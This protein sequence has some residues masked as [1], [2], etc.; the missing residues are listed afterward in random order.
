MKD[1]TNI[2]ICGLMSLNAKN[3]L[4]WTDLACDIGKKYNL[5]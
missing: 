5:K 4:N 3:G 2:M 1:K